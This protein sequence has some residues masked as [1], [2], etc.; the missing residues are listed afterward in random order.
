M[1]NIVLDRIEKQIQRASPAPSHSLF[2][3]EEVR[4]PPIPLDELREMFMNELAET[5]TVSATKTIHFHSFYD[6]VEWYV[7]RMMQFSEPQ[8]TALHTIVETRNM[9][10]KGCNCTKRNRENIA[11]EY[12]K[13][14]WM[15]NLD[16]DMIPT[17]LKVAEA[18]IVKFGN[19]LTYPA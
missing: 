2:V 5:E 11:D 14:F 19:F 8:R 1:L 7:P 3:Q 4:H 16:N 6:F 17:V 10:E 9:V 18:N 12:F 13:N 15:N